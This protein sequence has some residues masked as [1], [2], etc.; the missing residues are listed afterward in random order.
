[1]VERVDRDVRS[2]PWVSVI[3]QCGVKAPGTRPSAQ[4]L[5]TF[6]REICSIANVDA[7]TFRAHEM[8]TDAC[9]V[10]FDCRDIDGAPSVDVN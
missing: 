6:G 5:V 4:G 1:M 2:A 7:P 3:F 9:H 10:S 8:A